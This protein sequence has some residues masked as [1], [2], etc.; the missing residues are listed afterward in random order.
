[1]DRV[2]QGADRGK[3]TSEYR[4]QNCVSLTEDNSLKNGHT[5]SKQLFPIEKFSVFCF[6]PEKMFYFEESTVYKR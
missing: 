5:F 6:F 4:L 1:M 2:G 3:I